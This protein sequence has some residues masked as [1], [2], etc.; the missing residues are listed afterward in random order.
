MIFLKKMPRLYFDYLQFEIHQRE[1][2][3]SEVVIIRGICDNISDDY[4]ETLVNYKHEGCLSDSIVNFFDEYRDICFDLKCN[5]DSEYLRP[6]SETISCVF[7]PIVM[8]FKIKWRDF[9]IHEHNKIMFDFF[10]N[11]C[12]YSR[13][14]KRRRD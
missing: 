3:E 9:I 2:L 7:K 12:K 5:R 14:A 1:F 13:C 8:Y 6:M 11:H 4:E 10:S